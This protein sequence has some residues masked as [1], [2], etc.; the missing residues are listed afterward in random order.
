M[1]IS[2]PNAGQIRQLADA[3][4]IDMNDAEARELAALMDGNLAIYEVLDD[5]P[6]DLPPVKY[7]RT[8]GTQPAPAD[9]PMNA[10]YWQTDIPGADSGPLAGK[11]VVFKDNIMVAGVP[12]MNGSSTLEGYVPDVDATAVTRVLD[13]GGIVAG[14]A[15]SEYFCTSGGSHTNA[16]GP[17]HNPHRHGHTAG[18]SSSGCGALV[19]SGD[20]DMA[21][22]TDH[23]GSCR[24]PA[25][26]CGIVGMKATYGLVPY[27]GAMPIDMTIDYI[28]PMTRDVTDN[29]EL[30]KV[31]AGADG[32]DPMQAGI[33]TDDYTAALTGNVG[34]LRIAVVREGFGHANSDPAVDACV[35][36]AA[37]A[38]ERLG[39]RVE[40]V[41]IPMHAVSAAIW[42]PIYIEGL[43]V[44]MMH[45]NGFGKNRAGAFVPSLMRYH[46]GWRTQTHKFGP[47]TKLVMLTGE[48]MTQAYGGLYYAKAQNLRARLK[49]AYDAVLADH[50]VLLMPTLPLT[51]PP[52]PAA[53]ADAAEIVARALEMVPN[54]PAF[55]LTGHP[56]ISLPCGDVDGLP[57]GLMLCG[58][59]F[60]ESTVYRA[61][62]AYEQAARS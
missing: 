26:F 45:D 16:S 8:P 10:W 4:Y 40:E 58:R 17:I 38:F 44:S 21:V 49:A 61:A 50:D 23:G 12:M 30:L 36:E 60:E 31:L 22:G 19:A 56:S 27:T 37:R 51:A 41:S 2:R 6:D 29:A 24:I 9:N 7:P 28:G 35:R 25:S 13:A 5:L 14:K 3:V 54:T 34:D 48:Y 1:G 43:V 18:G 62:H 20:V 15:H 47:Q 59:H 46:A 11:R 33:R 32:I 42:T 52:L 39:A 55:D 53:D 57:V